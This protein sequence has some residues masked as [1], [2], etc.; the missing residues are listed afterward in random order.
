MGVDTLLLA[1]IDGVSY[2][3]LLFL[4]ALG[5]TFIF[6]VVRVLN[7][8]HGSLYA[9]GGYTAASMGIW[10]AQG[11]GSITLS[12]LA[13]ILGAG[14]VGVILGYGLMLLLHPFRDRDPIILLLVTFGAFMVLEDVQVMIWGT[15]PYFVSDVVFQ[16][17]D[18]E[19]LGVVFMNYQL[20]FIPS[21]ALAVYVLLRWFLKHSLKGRQ[22]IAVT[23]DR[24]VATAL[25]VNASSIASLTF[26]IGATLGALGGALAS[27]T[28]SLV[29]GVGADMIVLSFAVVATAGLGQ[30]SGALIVAL[31]IGISRSLSVYFLPQFEVVMP[32]LIMMAVLL[33][34]PQGLFTVA[35]ARRI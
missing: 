6:G 23:H 2:A 8:A 20:W 34:R 31:M 26:I 1:L 25:G 9:F 11:S 4:V 24:E 15:Q 5:L 22:I 30:I 27:P 21:V 33:I 18:S 32:Y 14:I 7:V 3:G 28:T 16:M 12:I 19:L 29:P 10:F 13:L 17:G 35:E